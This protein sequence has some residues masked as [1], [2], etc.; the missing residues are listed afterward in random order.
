MFFK[1]IVIDRELILVNVFVKVFFNF[2]Y[3]L[4]RCYI[5]KILERYCIN[6][7]KRILKFFFI[8]IVVYSG[9]SLKLVWGLCERDEWGLFI[10]VCVIEICVWDMIFIVKGEICLCMDGKYIVY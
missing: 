5:G 10:Y 6:L 9:R 1:I 2:Y 8:R 7:V 3:I 4:C